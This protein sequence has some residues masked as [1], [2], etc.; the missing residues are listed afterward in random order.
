MRTHG[1]IAVSR[2]Y[3]KPDNI[4]LGDRYPDGCEHS[5]DTEWTNFRHARRT[6]LQMQNCDR[7]RCHLA[8]SG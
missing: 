1:I 4:Q 5:T 2:D 3:N 7:L 6:G 8:G